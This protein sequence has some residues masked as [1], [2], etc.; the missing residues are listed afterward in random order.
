MTQSNT[1]PNSFMQQN[2]R[3]T[4]RMRSPRGK[5][6]S[7]EQSR[8]P[9]KDYLKR[10]STNS[11]SQKWHPPECMFYKSENRC[12]FGE[13]CSDK[14]GDKNALITLQITRKFGFVCQ[15]M[16]LPKSSSILQ[17]RSN[18]LK[19]IRCV[20]FTKPCHVMSALETKTHRLEW[21]A[22]V[23]LTRVHPILLFIRIGLLKRRNGKNDVPVKQRG[24][25]PKRS[26][27][28]K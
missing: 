7:G 2:E 16:E 15:D 19:S 9:C 24:N 23:I 5:S 28:E 18:I 14:Y 6:S 11:F 20:W 13:M 3:K 17:K 12:K 26:Y 22:Q 8:W 27:K 1:S 10:T 4:S 25:W 21:L